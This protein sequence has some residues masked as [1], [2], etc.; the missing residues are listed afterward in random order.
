MAASLIVCLGVLGLI[1]VPREPAGPCRWPGSLQEDRIAGAV[2]RLGSERVEERERAAA[3]LRKIGA[4]AIA[5]L[6]RAAEDKNPERRALAQILLKELLVRVQGRVAFWGTTEKENPSFSG[7]KGAVLVLDPEERNPR[8]V[9][10]GVYAGFEVEWAPGGEFLIARADVPREQRLGS[11]VFPALWRVKADGS[12][13]VP[14]TPFGTVGEFSISP[15]G[16]RVAYVGYGAGGGSDLWIVD[17]DGRNRRA[18]T[19]DCWKAFEPVWRPDGT[20]IVFAAGLQRDRKV[21]EGSWGMY[22]LEVETGM[23]VR[24]GD[25]VSHPSIT[26]DGRRLIALEDHGPEQPKSLL[27]LDPITG[28]RTAIARSANREERPRISPDGRQVA[29]VRA[30]SAEI[31]IVGIDGTGERTVADGRRPSWSPDGEHLAF[32]RGGSV[33]RVELATKSETRLTSGSRPVWS[34]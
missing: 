13:A 20:A 26:P 11:G 27:V 25:M 28:Q 34:K 9:L 10:T 32:E 7:A 33:Y 22:R 6:R 21:V 14:I 23:R 3:E 17:V 5:A 18:L 1:V 12:E 29:F 19:K 16:R 15:D 4:P 24:L 31:A 30:G 8:E 2:E